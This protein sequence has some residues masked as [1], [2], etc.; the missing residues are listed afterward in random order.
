MKYD[1]TTIID[2]AGKDA[3][4]FDGIGKTVWGFEPDKA[5]PGFDEIPMWVADMNFATCPAVVQ[6]MEQRL[7]HPLFG[8]FLPSDAYYQR[9]IDWQTTRHDWPELTQD[10]I[11]Y[12]N[13][14]HGGITST[15]QVLTE[16]GEDQ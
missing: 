3:T 8:Y 13:G 5:K 15:I 6:A 16:P 9:I 1:F 14:V 10:M 4:A 12:E 11:G 7:K 2:R